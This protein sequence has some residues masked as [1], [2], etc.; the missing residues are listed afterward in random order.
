MSIYVQGMLNDEVD[1][2][3]IHEVMLTK[4]SKIMHKSVDS[5]E[6]GDVDQAQVLMVPFKAFVQDNL[7]W[8]KK[9]CAFCRPEIRPRSGKDSEGL[10]G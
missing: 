1:A 4:Y 8:S 7:A 3:K 2:D 6:K 10:H 9:M 5:F